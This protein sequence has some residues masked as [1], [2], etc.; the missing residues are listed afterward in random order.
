MCTNVELKWTLKNFE[1]GSK[2]NI[3]LV[4][5]CTSTF[6]ISRILGSFLCGSCRFFEEHEN[7]SRRAPSPYCNEPS[8]LKVR[9]KQ[10]SWFFNKW[11]SRGRFNAFCCFF[12][13]NSSPLYMC[14]RAIHGVSG[15]SAP[16][17]WHLWQFVT[18]CDKVHEPAIPIRARR[19][20]T[21]NYANSK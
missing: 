11:L 17:L 6:L 5:W 16:N 20:V 4:L 13:G 8:Q 14:L 21:L 7:Q 15:G 3:D 9:Y 19:V 10:R 18:F 12:G 1:K 2:F